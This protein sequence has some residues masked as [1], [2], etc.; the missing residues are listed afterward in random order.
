MLVSY[1]PKLANRLKLSNRM[2]ITTLVLA[3]VC[4]YSAICPATGAASTLAPPQSTEHRAPYLVIHL[5]AVP[6]EVFFELYDSGLLPNIEAA[7]EGG[8]VIRHAVSPFCPG[9]EMLYPR[10]AGRGDKSDAYTVAWEYL[11]RTTGRHTGH[12]QTAADLFSGI[13]RYALTQTIHA[14]PGLEWLSGWSL[15]N[16]PRLMR[17]HDVVQFF[18]FATDLRGHMFGK[19]SQQASVMQL[20]RFIGHLLRHMQGEQFNLVLYSD[21]GMSLC[22]Q[23]IDPDKAMAN[24]A[25]GDAVFCYYPNLYLRDPKQSQRVAMSLAE[26]NEVDFAFFRV[27]ESEVV[28]VHAGGQ[29]IF[30]SDQSGISYRFDGDDPFG[31]FDI[32]Y[33][34]EPLSDQSWLDLTAGLRY[35]AVPVQVFRYMEA[36]TSGDV[37][38]VI[39]PPKGLPAVTCRSG[40]H[41][42]VANSH[43]TVPVLL[44]GPDIADI[45]I[46]DQ[47]WLHTLY[48]D[49]LQIDPRKPSPAER[50]PHYLKVSPE[51]LS[52]AVSPA[53]EFYIRADVDA[54][55]WNLLGEAS[56]MRTYNMRAWVGAGVAAS[57]GPA[58]D[59]AQLA[60]CTLQAAL[61]GRTEAFVG[62]LVF[63]WQKVLTPAG[64]SS[65]A[66]IR[67]EFE[68]GGLI[69]WAYPSQLRVGLVW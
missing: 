1:Q 15:L 47:F 53:R 50:E 45:E 31:Y 43:V 10:L 20:D 41:T 49:I 2:A 46:S 33:A 19:Q 12:A 42:G 18:W 69:E 14:L 34:G 17:D 23:V 21:H 8:R 67:Y 52:L 27:N 3:C 61:A 55:G 66:S 56:V 39:N 65:R 35:P 24:A 60:G 62:P 7:F 48:R 26:G 22:N 38:V 36:P 13:P 64:R 11:D 32:G 28:G 30:S 40:C 9:T 29:V 37:V 51:S 4:V 63:E 6:S 68:G 54:N 25:E 58:P 5:D 16:A 59:S 57:R 44:V